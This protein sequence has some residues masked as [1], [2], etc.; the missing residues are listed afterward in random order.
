MASREVRILSASTEHCLEAAA[1]TA[2]YSSCKKKVN[3]PT[4][5]N[6]HIIMRIFIFRKGESCYGNAVGGG[7]Q[8][9]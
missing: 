7:F 4:S 1:L 2:Q 6:C 9:G 8:P 5:Q 3:S